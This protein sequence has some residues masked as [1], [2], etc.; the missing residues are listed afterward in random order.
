MISGRIRALFILLTW[1]IPLGAFVPL[2]Y[3]TRNAESDEINLCS[4]DS[5]GLAGTISLIFLSVIFYFVP[6]IA[7]IILNVR[8]MKF[9]R[10]TNPVIKGNG[11]NRTQK[12]NTRVMKIL[13][14]IVVSFLVCW[15]LTYVAVFLLRFIQHFSKKREHTRKGSYFC[16]YFLPFLSTAVNPLNLFTFSTNYG[17]G[18]NDCILHVL[19]KCR[20]CFVPQ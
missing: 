19:V 17:Q 18:L 20:S 6:L 12:Q 2:F 16:P 9:L 5:R 15:T 14:S 10:R 8:I 4:I 1:I 13:I 3:Y 7:I 11:S